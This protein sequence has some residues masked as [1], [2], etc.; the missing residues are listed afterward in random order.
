MN[1]NLVVTIAPRAVVAASLTDFDLDF[2]LSGVNPLAQLF[3]F[4]LNFTTALPEFLIEGLSGDSVSDVLEGRLGDLG[5]PVLLTLG[6]ID[7][8]TDLLASYGEIEVQREVNNITVD[9]EADLN[10]QLAE[11][12]ELDENGERSFVIDG[13]FSRLLGGD[14]DL[15]DLLVLVR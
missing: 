10:E 11:A 14:V 7:A 1:G 13:D 2:S 9:L 12:L 8:L 15:D 3:S 5:I 4:I 6:S